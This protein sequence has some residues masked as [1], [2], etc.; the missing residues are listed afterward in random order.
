MYS[1]DPTAQSAETE[2]VRLIRGSLVRVIS[3]AGM[4]LLSIISTAAVAR[5]LGVE[6]FGQFT[7]VISVTALI[8]TVTDSGMTSV[9]TRQYAILA[10]AERKQILSTLLGIRTGLT[11]IGTSLAMLFAFAAHYDGALMLGMLA[12]SLA[13]FPLVVSHTLWIPVQNDLRIALLAGVD[14]ARQALWSGGLV[15]LAF[16]GAGPLPLLAVVLAVNCLMIPVSLLAARGLPRLSLRI[17]FQGWQRLLGESVTLSIAS[18]L[19]TAYLY[20]T[21]LITSMVATQ[22]ETGLFSVSFRLFTAIYLLPGLIGAAAFPLLARARHDDGRRLSRILRR[23]IEVS[24]V[25]GVGAALVVAAGAGFVVH[26]FVGAGYAGA[27]PAARIQALA[28]AG[29]FVSVPCSYG[30]MALG[31]HREL[32][33]ANFGTL[34]AMAVLTTALAS[35]AGAVGAAIACVCGEMILACTLMSRLWRCLRPARPN[36]GF[37]GKLTLVAAGAAPIAYGPWLPSLPRAIAAAALFVTLTAMTR[38]IP[39]EVWNA[40]FSPRRTLS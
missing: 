20:G 1:S 11:A 24:A 22:R 3:Y 19:A 31:L 15:V 18:V 12:A 9:V 8:A 14:L 5:D 33:L 30:L 35:S 40:V 4:L 38:A 6:R 26:A 34:I 32:M 27:V 7:A 13:T 23:Y 36:L 37:M 25:G 28:L 39:A 17:R 29:T 16:L 21:Q 2:A 10:G